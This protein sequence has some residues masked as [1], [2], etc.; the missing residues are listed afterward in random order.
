MPAPNLHSLKNTISLA[1]RLLANDFEHSTKDK[2]YREIETR[3]I[4]IY[5]NIKDLRNKRAQA[6]KT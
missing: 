2:E 1:L 5:M 3:L 6:G 4:D